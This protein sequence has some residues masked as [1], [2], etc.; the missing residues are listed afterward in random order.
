M[1][2][3]ARTS[4]AERL[5]GNVTRTLWELPN[6]MEAFA[7]GMEPRDHPDCRGRPMIIDADWKK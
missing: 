1:L 4:L 2:R 7:A 3:C 6:D 5:A